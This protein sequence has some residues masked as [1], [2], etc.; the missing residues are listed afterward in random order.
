M[1]GVEGPDFG[2]ILH[3]SARAPSKILSPGTSRWFAETGHGRAKNFIEIFD[4][5]LFA[6]TLNPSLRSFNWN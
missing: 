6:W 3:A 2:A 5:Y 1:Q 4:A